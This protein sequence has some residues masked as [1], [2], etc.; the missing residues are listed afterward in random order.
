[1]KRIY[2]ECRTNGVKVEFEPIKSGFLV[3]FHRDLAIKTETASE[4]GG[5]NGGINSLLA[6]VENNPG[7]KTADIGKGI[8]ISTR[9]AER[10][11]KKLRDDGKI[12]F[13][14]SKKTGGYYIKTIKNKDRGPALEN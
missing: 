12:E 3:I 5:I 9:T 8:N 14:G 13:R 4:D 6:Y 10:Y 1:L 11:I 2:D 7:K